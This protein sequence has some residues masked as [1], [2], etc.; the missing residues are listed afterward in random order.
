MAFMR[1]FLAGLGIAAM[2][3]STALAAT[4]EE[5]N[6]VIAELKAK[7]K[8]SEYVTDGEKTTRYEKALEDVLVEEKEYDYVRINYV[9]LEEN[10]TFSITLLERDIIQYEL[11][12]I[13]DG[14][15][16]TKPNGI[17]DKILRGRFSIPEL[18]EMKDSNESLKKYEHTNPD[19]ESK[20][21]FD[22]FV[23]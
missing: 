13:Y 16:N 21:L 19:E 9:P 3:Y 20:K 6:K 12:I 22:Y 10:G 2:L 17:P 5:I 18:L 15:N 7:G 14:N 23:K 11:I 4:P 8:Q 1:R